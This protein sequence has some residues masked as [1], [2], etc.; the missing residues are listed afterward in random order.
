MA[1]LERATAEIN[2]SQ[3]GVKV[4][5]QAVK[6]AQLYIRVIFEPVSPAH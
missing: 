2:F 6:N 1:L 4:I 5:Y 3:Y